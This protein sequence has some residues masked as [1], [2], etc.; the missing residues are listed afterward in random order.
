M[1]GLFIFGTVLR[2]AALHERLCSKLLGDA[3]MCGLHRAAIVTRH[4]RDTFWSA[5]TLSELFGMSSS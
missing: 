5:I 3:N 1:Y 4:N 2:I